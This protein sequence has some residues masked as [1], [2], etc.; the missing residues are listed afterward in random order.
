ME[1]R[2]EGGKG[3]RL[4]ALQEKEDRDEIQERDREWRN[5][6]PTPTQAFQVPPLLIFTFLLFMW[7]TEVGDIIFPQ[8]LQYILCYSAVQFLQ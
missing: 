8:T 3:K 1:R 6:T 7:N 5:V 2:G 4:H